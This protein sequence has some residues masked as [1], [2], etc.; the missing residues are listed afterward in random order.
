MT[1]LVIH[2]LYCVFEFIAFFI[3]IVFPLLQQLLDNA[4][5][6]KNLKRVSVCATT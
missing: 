5:H 1:D 4:N 2:L 3:K 6:K